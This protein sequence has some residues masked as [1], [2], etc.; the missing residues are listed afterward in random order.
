MESVIAGNSIF[1]V[2][3]GMPYPSRAPQRSDAIIPD[4]M[5]RC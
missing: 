1:V 2:K 5:K 4:H 3:Q